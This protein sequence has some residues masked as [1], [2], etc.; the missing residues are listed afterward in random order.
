MTGVAREI[1]L[2]FHSHGDALAGR[3]LRPVDDVTTRTPCVIVTGSWLTV[4]EQMASVYARRLTALGYTAF[5]FDFAGFGQSQGAPRQAELPA[6][7][8]ANIIDAAAFVHTMSFIDADRIGHLGVCASAQ[9]TLAALARGAPIA[10]FASVA[11]WYHDAASVA[12]FYG[13]P[14]GVAMR[15]E[16]AGEATARFL[17]SGEVITAPAYDDGNDRA[18][19]FFEVPYYGEARRGAVPS[20]TNA[21]A[22]MSWTYWLTFDGLAAAR[23][24]HTPTLI[25]HSDDCVLPD[26]A[27]RVHQDL[28]GTKELVWSTGAQ[29]DFYDQP[30]HVDRAMAAVGPWFATT[31]GPGL[32]PA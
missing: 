26:H 16:R 32:R 23:R 19:M 24:V 12:D 17:D 4:K 21:M 11:G 22:E 6:R 31:L 25:V 28:K 5:I 10:A 14:P 27:R 15:L 9:Y 2:V 29:M 20:W 7:K 13:G 30:D 8:I 3:F 1:P 18:A